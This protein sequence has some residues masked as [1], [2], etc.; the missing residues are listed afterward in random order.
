MDQMDYGYKLFDSNSSTPRSTKS[1][2][3]RDS[4]KDNRGDYRLIGSNEST[5]R[6]IRNDSAR[7]G[8]KKEGRIILPKLV[9]EQEFWLRITALVFF[10]LEDLYKDLLHKVGKLP[11][12]PKDLFSDLC[13]NKHRVEGLLKRQKISQQQYD[14]IYPRNKKT[15][16]WRFD[17]STFVFIVRYFTNIKPRGGWK[18]VNKLER[19]DK[20]KGALL[21]ELEHFI[22]EN[23]EGSEPIKEYCFEEM[24]NHILYFL[25]AFKVDIGEVTELKK[26]SLKD[27]TIPEKFWRCMMKAQTLYL[28]D[29]QKQVHKEL[30]ILQFEDEQC[31][32]K[33]DIS[34]LLD[35]SNIAQDMVLDFEEQVNSGHLLGTD[36]YSKLSDINKMLE[37]TETE[38]KFLKQMITFEKTAHTCKVNE[39]L[40]N[41]DHLDCDHSIDTS[42]DRIDGVG[43]C[44]LLV[45]II[46]II[47]F[48]VSIIPNLT[49][50]YINLLRAR[51]FWKY[52]VFQC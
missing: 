42:F 51:S 34:K 24:W 8:K 11:S 5:P 43:K 45:Y 4:K 48:N 12:N 20:S 46:Y 3:A 17:I 9:D 35:E 37:Q 23:I 41:G 30:L 14:L 28:S 38:M 26:C 50:N 36:L 21:I 1:D 32:N 44:L 15:E 33:E 18:L 25:K 16:I 7:D 22:V 27:G 52:A 29:T 13:K 10:Y 47:R 6:L 40:A 31:E 49:I 2:T 19:G 39:A